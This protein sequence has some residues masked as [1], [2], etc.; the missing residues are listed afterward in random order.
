MVGSEAAA[1]GEGYPPRC[2]GPLGA[3]NKQKEAIKQRSERCKQ[4]ASRKKQ[5]SSKQTEASQQKEASKQASKQAASITKQASSIRLARHV[6][7]HRLYL[8]CKQPLQRGT[9]SKSLKKGH[10]HGG[11]DV[12]KA[13]QVDYCGFFGQSKVD[14]SRKSRIYM[15]L[16]TAAWG[17][18]RHL[19]ERGPLLI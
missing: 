5:S 14:R 15:G 17:I 3:N 18:Q 13:E 6:D 7:R 4:T 8:F 16:L 9:A 1:R 19:R 10:F 2:G 12:E 11:L